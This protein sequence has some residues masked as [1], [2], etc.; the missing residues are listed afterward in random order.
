MRARVFV[1]IAI[2]IMLVPG[3]GN[4]APPAP[5]SE[6]HQVE[7][8]IGDVE[9]VADVLLHDGSSSYAGNDSGAYVYNSLTSERGD[10]FNFFPWRQRAFSIQTPLVND[11]QPVLCDG[12]SRVSAFSAQT[13]QWYEELGKRGDGGSL[14][15]DASITCSTDNAG[16]A[17]FGVFY[18]QTDP[19]VALDLRTECVRF[20]RI[21]GTSYTFSAPGSTLQRPCEAAVYSFT[22]P[23][24][25]DWREYTFLGYSSAPFEVTAVFDS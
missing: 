21:S 18:P 14:L 3:I 16:K 25:S 6:L 17:G 4:A 1:F 23:R 9:G 8:A 13:P 2:A 10:F 5:T 24:G 19:D 11:G 12:F 7:P 20:T 22:N 15:G